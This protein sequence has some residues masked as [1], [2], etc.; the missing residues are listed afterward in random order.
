MIVIIPHPAEELKLIK[1]QKQLISLLNKNGTVYYPALPMWIDF[2]ETTEALPVKQQLKSAAE[3]IKQISFS[4]LIASKDIFIEIKIE[5]DAKV[6]C[7]KLCILRYYK[8]N[9]ATQADIETATLPFLQL[10]IFRTAK[11]NLLSPVTCTTAD[12]V[13]KKL[14]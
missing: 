13:W 14:Q 2:Q 3:S 6:F 12:S 9:E 7:T 10:K 11:K 8:G 5:T 1:F 4:K